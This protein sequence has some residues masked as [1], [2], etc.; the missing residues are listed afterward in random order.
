VFVIFILCNRK[1]KHSPNLEN[2]NKAWLEKQAKTCGHG[3]QMSLLKI[4]RG[5]A[6]LI[7]QN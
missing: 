4:G 1:S 6:Q 3:D 2:D 7:W 5:I